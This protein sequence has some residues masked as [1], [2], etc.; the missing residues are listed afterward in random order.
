M[1]QHRALHEVGSVILRVYIFVKFLLNGVRKLFLPGMRNDQREL[2]I[3]VVER[4]FNFLTFV[5]NFLIESINVIIEY[6]LNTAD[7]LKS[8][9]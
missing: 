4:A 1:V 3:R 8:V 2:R 7:E 6:A 5:P 9:A